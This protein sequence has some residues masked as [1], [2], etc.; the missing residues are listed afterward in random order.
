M[1]RDRADEK[2]YSLWKKYIQ[3]V[4]KTITSIAPPTTDDSGSDSDSDSGDEAIVKI[5]MRF[6]DKCCDDMECPCGGWTT[7][8][9]KIKDRTPA[10]DPSGRCRCGWFRGIAKGL[11]QTCDTFIEK[12]H[13]CYG[14]TIYA[15]DTYVKTTQNK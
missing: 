1:A 12:G 7:T 8:E 3:Q 5:P 15:E 13:D 9:A 11:F 4:E 10:P 14:F 2:V 6:T